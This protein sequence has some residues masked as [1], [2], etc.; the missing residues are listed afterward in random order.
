RLNNEGCNIPGSLSL[1]YSSRCVQKHIQRTLVVL[2]SNSSEAEGFVTKP[3]EFPSCCS[4]LITM[5]FDAYDFDTTPFDTDW[6]NT[7][8]DIPDQSNTST[9]DASSVDL[10]SSSA[11]STN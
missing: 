3:F 11:N 8:S 10:T 2:N 5:N 4:C 9:T 7:T 6:Y 1:G